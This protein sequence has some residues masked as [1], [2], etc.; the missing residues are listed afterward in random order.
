MVR[1][2]GAG[3]RRLGGDDRLA[4]A[5]LLTGTLAAILTRTLAAAGSADPPRVRS[6]GRP[7]RSDRGAAAGDRVTRMLPAAA[8]SGLPVQRRQPGR[9]REAR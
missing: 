5:T 8:A 2:R 9:D 4:A 7:G 3:R 6:P 1:G